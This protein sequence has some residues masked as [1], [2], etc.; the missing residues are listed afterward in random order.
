MTT[1]RAFLGFAAFGVG[2]FVGGFRQNALAAEARPLIDGVGAACKRLAP[3]GWR[4]LLLEATGGEL[5]ITEADLRTELTKPLARI[6]RTY[7]GFGDFDAA[8][9]RAI[10]RG[11]PDRSLLYH[12]FASPGV[13]ADRNGAALGGFPTLAEI[14]AVENFVYGAEP[15]TL[16]ELQS[17]AEGR[18]LG[19]AV[20]ALQYRNTPLSVHGQHAELCFARAGIAR[21]GSIEPFYDAA[22]RNFTTGDE[23]RPFDFRVVPRRFAAYVAVKASGADAS[24]GPQDALPGDRDLAFWVPIHK[25]FSGPECIAGRDLDLELASGLR[26]DELA[27]FHRFLELNGLQNNWGGSDLENF[28]FVIKD[29]RIGSLSQRTDFGF[30]VLEPRP[31]PLTVAA[32][33]KGLPLTFPVDGRYTSEPDELQFSSLQVLPAAETGPEPRYIQDAAQSTQRPAPEY[34]NIRHRLAANGA[35]DNLNLRPDMMEIIRQG[36]YQTLHYIDFSGDGWI[37]ARC[38]QLEDAIAERMPAYCMVGLPDFF[39]DVTQRGLMHWWQNS[40]PRAGTR[41]PLG[42]PALC[43]LADANRG[44]R[45]AARGVQP[46]GHDDHRDRFATGGCAGAHPAAERPG[47]RFQ[48]GAAGRLA[49]PVRSRMGH[50]PGHLFHGSE[51]KAAEIPRRLWPRIAVRR[52]RQALRR[53]RQLLAGRRTGRDARLPARQAPWRRALSLSDEHPAHRRGDRQRA[54]RRGDIHAV[55]RRARPGAAQDRR[56]ARRR[57]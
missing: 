27:Q 5:D 49:R 32:Q 18:T 6:D 42:D 39:P 20:Y 38:P 1:R 47:V 43:P 57:L 53:A 23:A 10:S 55:G 14:E 21:L 9:V 7:P 8:G 44:E 2:A 40:V 46:R 12:A 31:S 34:L 48:G 50:E 3:L 56:T 16:A 54:T 52:G 24:F 11:N 36:G 13:L 37:A 17:R 33:Y 25:L 26:N 15:P 22:R 19:I 29:E 30:G 35:I 45:H 28:P 41:C 4:Q 51:A